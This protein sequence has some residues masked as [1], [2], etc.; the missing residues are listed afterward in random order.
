M[1]FDMHCHTKEGSMDGKV[2]IEE[3]IRALKRKGFGGMLVSDHNSYDG[4]R[5]WKNAIKGKTHQDFVV[6]KGVEYDTCDCGHILVIMPFGVKLKILELR[7]LPGSILIR[8]VHAYGGILGPAHPY[9]E[10]FM[11]LITTNQGKEKCRE[12]IR[13]L[14]PQ[15]DFVE[16]YNAC[17]EEESNKKAKHLAEIYHKP[18]FGGS[19]AH[20]LNCIGTAFTELPDS[21][22]SEDDLIAYVKTVP[23]ITCGG[24][25][26][27]GTT[28]GK[29]G[30]FGTALVDSFYLYNKVANVWRGRSRKKE[31]FEIIEKKL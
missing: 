27:T 11:S 29:M 31:L 9:G 22:R 17:E 28:R 1:K 20:K 15:F 10:K 30:R 19:D 21:I 16:I 6:L 5:E 14:M 24:S 23:E 7:G 26:Y 18:G 25:H 3:Y 13:A 2:M 4:Y 8:I 12:R